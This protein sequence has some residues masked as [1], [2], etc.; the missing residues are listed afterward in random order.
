MIKATLK[1]E[2]MKCGMCESHVN[3]A[4]RKAARVKKVSSSHLTG[5]TKVLCYE[6]NDVDKIVE[7]IVREGY[8]VE[9]VKVE[10]YEKHGLFVKL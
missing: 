1:V 9:V 4:A 7:N 5:M 8:G 10:P 2:G 3:E 6:P